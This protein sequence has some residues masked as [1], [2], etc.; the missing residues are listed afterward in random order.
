MFDSKTVK[1]YLP[2][3]TV[4]LAAFL[5]Y[6]FNNRKYKFER[7]HKEAAESL[8][9]FYSPLFHEMR[10][11]KLDMQYNDKVKLIELFLKKHLSE[12]TQIYKSYNRKLIDLFYDLDIAF[13]GYKDKKNVKLDDVLEIYNEIFYKVNKDYEDIQIC[14]YS[15]FPW[16]K[17][18]HKKSPI[19]R[20]L[21]DLGVL[22][23]DIVKFIF[24]GWVLLAYTVFINKL[25]GDISLPTVI[26]NNFKGITIICVSLY[27]FGVIARL[28]YYF[29]VT[30]YKKEN[31]ILK[32]ADKFIYSNLKRIFTR[33]KSTNKILK[34]A[35]RQ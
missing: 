7:F 23:Y 22:F 35:V 12:D 6:I 11:I 4:I 33:K 30:D 31:K 21:M 13:R 16:Y 18:L 19:F 5:A 15:Q 3:I 25:T 9:D 1:D 14:L 26:T 28:P 10:I 29:A 2:V 20:I 8:K 24:I 34:K 32:K 17:L 27:L